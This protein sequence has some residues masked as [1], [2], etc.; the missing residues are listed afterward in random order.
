MS[1]KR[2]RRVRRNKALEAMYCPNGRLHGPVVNLHVML[3]M[4]YSRVA[5]ALRDQYAAADALLNKL[6]PYTGPRVTFPVELA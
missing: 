1:G 5:D 3:R 4:Y 6:Q 2:A